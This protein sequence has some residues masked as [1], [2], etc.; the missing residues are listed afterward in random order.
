MATPQNIRDMAINTIRFNFGDVL[1]MS[2]GIGTMYGFL[3]GMKLEIV[4]DFFADFW[5]ER[6][7]P[8]PRNLV[9]PGI[10]SFRENTH[11]LGRATG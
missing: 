10:E 5:R 7:S 2:R 11:L 3:W 8:E 9:I 6:K 1:Q 4:R